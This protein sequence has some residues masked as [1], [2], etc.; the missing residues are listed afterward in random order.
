MAARDAPST[1]SPAFRSPR[2]TSDQ[3]EW[4]PPRSGYL[5]PPARPHRTAAVSSQSTA[6]PVL[7]DSSSNTR[8]RSQS[9]LARTS[10]IEMAA[11]WRAAAAA[12]CHPS[13][14]CPGIGYGCLCIRL[15]DRDT[16]APK[17]GRCTHAC[18]AIVTADQRVTARGWATIFRPIAPD[19]TG[20][21]PLPRYRVD[22][23][24]FC[25]RAAPRSTQNP[26][27]GPPRTSSVGNMIGRSKRHT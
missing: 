14:S 9:S 19:E 7:I 23:G 12:H 25:V 26:D 16:D 24:W 17:S 20:A 15:S 13:M 1:A 6:Q 22:C 18:C 4:R 10:P 21:P 2:P 8:V 3:C 27:R 11:A 5:L